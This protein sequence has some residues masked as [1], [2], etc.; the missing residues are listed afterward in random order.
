[1][2]GTITVQNL[3]APTSGADAYKM[4]VPSGHTLY[5]P[6]HVLQV[7]QGTLGTTASGATAAGADP[8]TPTLDTGAADRAPEKDWLTL[9][10]RAEK[11]CAAVSNASSSSLFAA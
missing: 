8:E 3:Q 7:V 1:M 10:M 11:S 4:F 5:A 6:G 9:P 2:V